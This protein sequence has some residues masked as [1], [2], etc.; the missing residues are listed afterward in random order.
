M[1]IIIRL[2]FQDEHGFSALH[3]AA[4]NGNTEITRTL[5]KA[6]A[7]YTTV[8]ARCN[9]PHMIAAERGHADVLR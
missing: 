4:Y 7:S 6:G 1:R 5:L 3:I 2:L 9:L 8:S